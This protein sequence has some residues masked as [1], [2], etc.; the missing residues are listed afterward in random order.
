MG[1]FNQ[2]IK[3]LDRRVGGGNLV[4]SVVVDQ[5]YAKYQHEDLSLRHPGGGKAGYLRDPLFSGHTGWLRDIAR[6]ILD[7]GAPQA[8]ASAME[9]LSMGV[10]R[11]APFEFGDLKASP[12]PTVTDDGTVTYN[13]LPM[14]HRLTEEEIDIKYE[15]RNLGLGNI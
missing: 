7:G 14:I 15:L 11:E 3:E 4:G 5:V 12:H 1:T 8:M 9:D 6:V 13:R 2:R 10:Y